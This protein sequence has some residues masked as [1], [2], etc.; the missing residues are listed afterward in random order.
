MSSASRPGSGQTALVTG[1]SSGIGADLAECFAR[2]GY[3]LIL[4]A[5][6]LPALEQVAARL[7]REHGVAATPIACDLAEVGGARKLA[8]AI[9]ASGLQADVLVN[10][11]G[12]G[13]AGPF[14]ASDLGLLTFPDT[15][16]N[17]YADNV[18][19][20]FFSLFGPTPPPCP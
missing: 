20:T 8:Q 2:G 13:Q 17:C 3:D 16:G 5:R 19:T 15:H 1:A 12:Y 6:S 14:T 9:T 18:F 10:N 4:T 11:A 7:A